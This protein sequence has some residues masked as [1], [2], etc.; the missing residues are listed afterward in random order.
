MIHLIMKEG[1]PVGWELKPT[2]PEEH[3]VAGT[4]RDMQFFGMGDTYPAYNGIEL[5]DPEKGKVSGNLK[6]V[7]WLQKKH[8]KS[9]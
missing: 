3:E 9:T 7:S 2:T 8:H 5:I 4:I 6:S 1:R